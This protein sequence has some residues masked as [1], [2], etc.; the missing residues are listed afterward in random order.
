[1]QRALAIALVASTS[2]FACGG[3]S[4]DTTATP[5]GSGGDCA[6]VGTWRAVAPLPA[7]LQDE[8]PLF[9]QWV[10]TPWKD[11]HL[12]DHEGS[13]N[14]VD[15][16]EFRN[17][18]LRVVLIDLTPDP[19]GQTGPSQPVMGAPAPEPDPNGPRLKPPRDTGTS[20][21]RTSDP[22]SYTCTL[23]KDCNA[24]QCTFNN[25]Q[26]FTMNRVANAQ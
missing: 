1:M 12:V 23:A 8:D 24:F 26:A 18:E 3:K 14:S 20:V 22:T 19:K 17:G 25:G 9:T 2:L 5:S 16:A 6:P 4:P 21:R 10:V 13:L 11:K 7:A 15:E